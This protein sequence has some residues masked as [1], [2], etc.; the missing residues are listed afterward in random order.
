MCTCTILQVQCG[1][2]V[3]TDSRG[4]THWHGRGGKTENSRLTPRTEVRLLKKKLHACQKKS[5]CKIKT[6]PPLSEAS[7]LEEK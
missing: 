5:T 1:G 7:H 6:S 4:D 2:P 3:P